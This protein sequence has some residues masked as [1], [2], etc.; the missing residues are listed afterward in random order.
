MTN[1]TPISRGIRSLTALAVISTLCLL[2]IMVM[3]PLFRQDIFIHRRTL[4]GPEIAILI[5]YVIAAL[6]ILLSTCWLA[7]QI[8]RPRP[9]RVRT[10]WLAAFGLFCLLLFAAEKVMIDEI[11]RE[12]TLG[13]ETT[14]EWIILY[15]LL[16]V[17]LV[18]HLVVRRFLRRG[19]V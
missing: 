7:M 8:I 4:S 18:Y 16:A 17:Q 14:G 11:G 10:A 2:F 6:F 3:L 13:W 12:T 15:G 9:D 19:A 5:G 1:H